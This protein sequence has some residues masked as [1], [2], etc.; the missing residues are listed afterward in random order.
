MVKN[1]IFYS[2]LVFL[3]VCL[4]SH[5]N[6]PVVQSSTQV[7]PQQALQQ[8]NIIR[9]PTTPSLKPVSTATTVTQVP[10]T[11]VSFESCVRAYQTSTDNLFLLALAAINASGYKIDEMQSRTGLVSFEAE[12][13]FFLIS[14]TELD[15][16]SSMLKI[17]PMNNSYVFS[18]VIIENIFHYLTS[19][20]K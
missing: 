19:N 13:K 3:C 17:S 6:T 7:T 1:K 9:P 15:E 14:V 2:F 20:V 16:H 5:A 11:A 12:N 10:K 4:V 18:P 8:A